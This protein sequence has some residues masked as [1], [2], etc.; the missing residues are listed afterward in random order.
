DAFGFNSF[1]TSTVDDYTVIKGQAR[2]VRSAAGTLTQGLDGS[3]GNSSSQ[4]VYTF[5]ENGKLLSVEEVDATVTRGGVTLAAKGTVSLG[6][7]AFGTSTQTITRNRYIVSALGQ[8]R[9]A[10]AST[11]SV[12]S[13]VDGSQA[14][15]RNLVRYAY[16]DKSRAAEAFEVSQFDL[17]GDGDF[18]DDGERIAFTPLSSKAWSKEGVTDGGSG[19]ALFAG[20]VT[21][22][23]DTFGNRTQTLTRNLYSMTRRQGDSPTGQIRVDRNETFAF[24]LNLDGT[25]AESH[26]K[27]DYLYDDGARLTDIQELSVSYLD[28]KDL[29][30]QEGALVV[31]EAIDAVGNR[32]QTRA[33]TEYEPD[34]K[35]IVRAMVTTTTT[36][37]KGLEGG[38]STT[39]SKVTTL[40]SSGNEQAADL[41]QTNY[42]AGGSILPE[43]DQ[44]GDG[45]FD[46]VGVAIGARDEL[47]DYT[48]PI[49]RQAKQHRGTVTVSQEVG[50]VQNVNL[51]SGT[52]RAISGMIRLANSTTQGASASPDGTSGKALSE[53]SY[54]YRESA[55]GARGE[56]LAQTDEE[57][58]LTAFGRAVTHQGTAAISQSLFG[59]V[60]ETRISNNETVIINGQ[61]RQ[62]RVT[63]T[64]AIYGPVENVSTSST[65]TDSEYDTAGRLTSQ[66]NQT[67]ANAV[68][69]DGSTS[70]TQSATRFSYGLSADQDGDGTLEV[71]DG[72]HWGAT[73]VQDLEIAYTH[74]FTAAAETHTGAV[75]TTTDLFGGKGLIKTTSSYTKLE[76]SGLFRV[77]QAITDSETRS[78]QGDRSI[79]RITTTNSY[80]TGNENAGNLPNTDYVDPATG[81]IRT[82]Y[83]VVDFDGSQHIAAGLLKGSSA[84]GNS[85]D[86]DLLGN[87]TT[88]ADLDGDGKAG[89]QQEFVIFHNQAR[90]SG[91]INEVRAQ[92][93]DGAVSTSRFEQAYT[94]SQ[95]GERSDDTAIPWADTDYLAGGQFKPSLDPDGDGKLNHRGLLLKVEGGVSSASDDILGNRTVSQVTQRYDVRRQNPR[96]HLVQTQ[97]H[98]TNI[99]GSFSDNLSA[100]RYLYTEGGETAADLE[101]PATPWADTDYVTG[102]VVAAPF[103][104]ADGT[105]K[106]Q[107]LVM[108]AQDGEI[109]YADPLLQADKTAQAGVTIGRDLGGNQYVNEVQSDYRVI[110]G[111]AV[112]AVATTDGRNRGPDGTLGYSLGKLQYAYNAQGVLTG[113][114]E[115][116]ATLTRDLN[117]DGDTSDFAEET[118]A[119]GTIFINRSPFGDHTRQVSDTTYEAIGAIGQVRPRSVTTSAETR[120]LFGNVSTS[121]TETDSTY[122]T[123]GRLTQQENH[124]LADGVNVDGSTSHTESRSGFGYGLVADADG[125]ENLDVADGDRWG[126]ESAQDLEVGYAD[127]FTGLAENH[128]GPVT[129]TTDLFGGKGLVKTTN[130]YTVLNASLIRV[131]RAAAQSET[132]SAQGDVSISAVTTVYGYTDGTETAADLDDPSTP[133]AET[134]YV[135]PV[136]GAIRSEYLTTDQGG[137][138]LLIGLLKSAAAAGASTDTDLF[139]NV[140][141]PD[142]ID[143]DGLS[144]IRQEFQVIYGQAKIRES[145]N[146][147][148]TGNAFTG[149]VTTAKQVLHYA[150]SAETP[151]RAQDLEDP[152]TPWADTDYLNAD[153]TLKANFDLNGDG[154][155]DIRGLLVRVTG[156]DNV[157]RTTDFFGNTSTTTSQVKYLLRRSTP[158]LAQS[159]AA[160]E[161]RNMDGSS[162]TSHSVTRSSYSTGTEAGADLKRTNYVL[163]GTDTL[164]PQFDPDGNGVFNY[165]NL[166]AAVEETE[167]S[168]IDPFDGSSRQFTGAVTLT[169]DVFGTQGVITASNRYWVFN[170]QGRPA[171]AATAS[172]T[173]T[174]DGTY[175]DGENHAVYF[176]SD[177][178]QTADDLRAFGNANLLDPD[179]TIKDLYDQNQNGLLDQTGVLYGVQEGILQGT[180]LRPEEVTGW[181]FD[182]PGRPPQT[183]RGQGTVISDPFGSI[184][185]SV[186][187]TEYEVKRGQALAKIVSTESSSRGFDGTQGQSA[188]KVAY[189]YDDKGFLETR[190]LDGDGLPDGV[191]ELPASMT[192][193][194]E[195]ISEFPGTI[196]INQDPFGTLTKTFQI[197]ERFIFILNK[198]LAELTT[199]QT[200][201][202]SF[203]GATTLTLNKQQSQFTT[204]AEVADLD[205]N[206]VVSDEELAQILPQADPASR[207]RYLNATG[208]AFIP[209]LLMSAADRTISLQEFFGFTEADVDPGLAGS[210]P[211]DF[212]GNGSTADAEIAGTLARTAD[213]LGNE[214]Q[215]VT[216]TDYTILLG[217]ALAREAATRSLGLTFDLARSVTG[218]RLRYAYDPAAGRLVDVYE[219]EDAPVSLSEAELGALTG[220]L[221][222]LDGDGRAASTITL[223]GSLSA[224]QDM[225]GT[226]SWTHTL[227]T[228]LDP[229]LDSD[230]DGRPD[231]HG[232]TLAEETATRTITRTWDGSETTTQNLLLYS[233]DLATTRLLDTRE[234]VPY[235]AMTP[236]EAAQLAGTEGQL[237]LVG[238]LDSF[239]TDAERAQR[240]AVGGRVGLID[241]LTEFLTQNPAATPEETQAFLDGREGALAA[242]RGTLQAELATLTGVAGRAARDRRGEINRRL[243]WIEGWLAQKADFLAAQ[244][245]IGDEIQA[246]IAALETERAGLQA[247]IA[248]LQ[249]QQADLTGQLQDLDQTLTALNDTLASLTYSS[250]TQQ[251]NLLGDELD[252]LE[253]DRQELWDSRFDGSPFGAASNWDNT[254]SG[255]YTDYQLMLVD[256]NN[257]GL[258]DF[259]RT[260]KGSGGTQVKV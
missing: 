254:T 229:M 160:T 168:Y 197:T 222:D 223:H 26:G 109:S 106:W 162:S 68:N 31:T 112:V 87:M 237:D 169:Q 159:D 163:P 18:L 35:G 235:W 161:T 228:Y 76:S 111:R 193:A 131:L 81:A 119:A 103:A 214:T 23:T 243:A 11:E 195:T 110:L 127:P 69:V 1:T 95:A 192:F 250:L 182:Y 25:A 158:L 247:E 212:N 30:T 96:L 74:P 180:L 198:P 27:L 41:A 203:D 142:D 93:V 7:D 164:K 21:D 89:I 128:I 145:V 199:V 230:A 171:E 219:P 37:G 2:V 72:D 73:G 253:W 232:R 14:V 183:I 33:A 43:F 201:T 118:T 107:N 144:G 79:S 216:T 17:N 245:G 57:V 244:P 210:Q 134:D 82:D 55:P 114:D 45:R 184:S 200:E 124:T 152:S 208:L 188:S 213:L 186:T 61:A 121:L 120:D 209:A 130:T 10:A 146:E 5:D 100:T 165:G 4:L 148:R 170:G 9:V 175:S 3:G 248:D 177:G 138:R 220:T 116:E 259:V 90:L 242:E 83:L 36:I 187:Q 153:G 260:W 202:R 91:S 136:T 126:V 49:D 190:D 101:D 256:M 156:D 206:G 117:G 115:L 66:T 99:D 240:A 166:L 34:S 151:M 97:A 140:T 47:V 39:V 40:Y 249:G 98:T 191:K 54:T 150:Y 239:L 135:D 234:G 62:R 179:G 241:E 205:G 139:G 204:G 224:T 53:V 42:A 122:D 215:A 196:S 155:L 63:T 123:A 181:E 85:T 15:S 78:L 6:T 92:M 108:G 255:N 8:A 225:L 218:S 70:Q 94:Y 157:T 56:L 64:A 132:R 189:T 176:F 221:W 44:N 65:Q 233:Y 67:T 88:S 207:R 16:D 58:T 38:I 178:S 46:L 246:Q 172:R 59:D 32:T 211:F 20:T 24:T 75:T 102:G 129:L 149:S 104:A 13:N 105:M 51:V 12:V 29:G 77:T 80:T 227:T 19:M 60:T 257:D 22:T 147:S 226:T 48:D 84:A 174:A 185:V 143:G 231:A 28:L 113:A 133:W 50:G 71:A 194:G 251:I 86:T 137:T 173:K 238:S 154:L 236:Q 167:V 258:A 217:R 141:T 125:D 52:Y 252:D